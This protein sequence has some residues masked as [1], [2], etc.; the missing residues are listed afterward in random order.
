MLSWVISLL[1]LLIIIWALIA[2]F[3]KCLRPSYI[4]LMPF[5]MIHWI[6]LDDTC[7]LTLIENKLRGCAKEETFMH[8]LVGGIYNLPDG[9]LGKLIWI[10]VIVTWVYA[11]SKTSWEDIKKSLWH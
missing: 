6:L 5:I 10:Y 2:P 3:T 4:L 8:R 7:V 9:I 1:H 11:V